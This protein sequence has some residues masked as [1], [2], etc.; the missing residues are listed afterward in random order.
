[1]SGNW[2]GE[3]PSLF[4]LS[5]LFSSSASKKNSPNP[6]PATL[7]SDAISTLKRAARRAW[8]V[9]AS[10]TLAAILVVEKAKLI[11]DGDTAW[12]E[13]IAGGPQVR[14]VLSFFCF[15]GFRAFLKVFER[16]AKNFFAFQKQQGRRWRL[17][18]T[19]GTDQVRKA[20]AGGKAGGTYIPITAVQRWRLSDKLIENGIYLGGLGAFVF[21]GKWEAKGKRLSFDFFSVRLRL[22]PWSKDF[23]MKG[24]KAE[25]EA[26]NN[27]KSLGPFFL[28]CYADDDICV[29]RGRGGGVALWARAAGDWQV[30]AGI[31]D[32]A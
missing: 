13:E 5:I 11:G 1:M 29:A 22:G 12:L 16:T 14:V 21:S 30:K 32:F 10:E 9:P 2:S 18:F 19:S 28:F 23:A 25:E 4:S 8:A 6:T 17:M 24:K 27:K 31:D 26:K 15:S 7:P 20:V 3:K